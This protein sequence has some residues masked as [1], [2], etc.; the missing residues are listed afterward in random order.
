MNVTLNLVMLKLS[1]FHF[2]MFLTSSDNRVYL[3]FY[4]VFVSID[5]TELALNLDVV[6]C[7]LYYKIH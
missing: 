4:H 1:E 3:T 2:F 7:S 5:T 6:F